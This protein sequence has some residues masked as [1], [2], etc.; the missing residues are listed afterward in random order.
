MKDCR[1]DS[2]PISARLHNIE[3]RIEW[4]ESHAQWSRDAVGIDPHLARPRERTVVIE[5]HDRL[6][7]LSRRARGD[8]IERTR[9]INR[10][11]ERA[12]GPLIETLDGVRDSPLERSHRAFRRTCSLAVGRS[13]GARGARQRGGSY[14]HRHQE[15]RDGG[16]REDCASPQAPASYIETTS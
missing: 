16:Q 9:L 4:A 14:P 12:R 6:I 5:Q 1:C 11:R 8:M 13:A 7:R 10:R 3:R 15:K 2:A